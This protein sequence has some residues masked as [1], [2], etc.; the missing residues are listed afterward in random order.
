MSLLP[1]LAPLL[2]ALIAATCAAIW[3]VV[4]PSGDPRKEGDYRA[5]WRQVGTIARDRRFWRY[6]PMS[7]A[8]QATV[9]SIG[10][11]W[12]GPWLRDVAGLPDHVAADG[13]SVYSV[14][15]L[16]GFLGTGWL[17]QQA[18][19]HR[20][21]TSMFVA[22]T[23]GFVAIQLMIILLP[24]A[25]GVWLWIAY[26]TLGVFAIHLYATTAR[27][28]PVAMAGRVNALHNFIVFVAAFFVQWLFGVWL[29]RFP[30]DG[31]G[32]LRSGYDTGFAILVVLQLASLLPLALLRERR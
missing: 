4:P 24:A 18:G 11:L 20:L 21:D 15:V 8:T 31:G 14:G 12:T 23:I 9:L 29:D 25:V 27:A 2:A 19:R 7:T 5:L 3:L 32:A 10:S 13:L 28:F 16:V 22:L 17:A 26:M 1:L 6:V 30:A